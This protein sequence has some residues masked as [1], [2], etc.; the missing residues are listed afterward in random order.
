[1]AGVL[2]HEAPPGVEVTTAAPG[3]PA[4]PAAG[5][6]FVSLGVWPAISWRRRRGRRTEA[7]PEP[8]RPVVALAASGVLLAGLGW[9]FAELSK[10]S[11]Q[12]GLSER[13]AAG[14][15]ALWPLAAVLITRR[16]ARR[17]S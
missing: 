9:F 2:T 15:Q 12:V 10:D 7:V 11:D 14:N 13:V 5:I 6:A 8:F 3:R 17:P 1:M 4:M 16:T